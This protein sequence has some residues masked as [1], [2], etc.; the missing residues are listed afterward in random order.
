M[1]QTM[2]KPSK[3]PVSASMIQAQYH[4]IF[5]EDLNASNTMFGGQMMRLLDRVALV[6]AERHSGQTCA[7][8]AVD[9]LNFI[10][11]AKQGDILIFQAALN[12]SWQT[13]MEV[14][15]RVIA[16]NAKQNLQRHVASGYFIFAAVDKD[17]IPTLVAPVVPESAHEKR[18]YEEADLRRRYREQKLKALTQYRAQCPKQDE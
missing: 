14:G 15:V 13:S 7:T 2:L 9:T 5:P 18:R 10:G 16:E 11:P 8:V 4:K 1:K 6:V 17:R 12:R 3:K